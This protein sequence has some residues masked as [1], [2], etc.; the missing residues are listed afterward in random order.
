MNRPAVA[1]AVAVAVDRPSGRELGRP[2]LALLHPAVEH[3]DRVARLYK[4]LTRPANAAVSGW[5]TA[6]SRD[7]RR[8]QA[9]GVSRVYMTERCCL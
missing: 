7:E 4:G 8:R 9:S 6:R 2:R 1:V 5:W 3:V